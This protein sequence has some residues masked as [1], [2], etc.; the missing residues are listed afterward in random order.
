MDRGIRGF[1][2]TVADAEPDTIAVAGRAPVLRLEGVSKRFG[3]RAVLREVDLALAPGEVVAICGRNGAG[4]TTLLRIAAGL[5]IADAGSVRI[6]GLDPERD[7]RDYQRRVGLLAAG[8]SG[9]Y[10]RLPVERHLDFCAGI[11]LIP[12][13]VRRAA[14]ERAT[15]AFDL[16]A[17][18]GLR[19]DR[20]SMGQRQRLRLALA[21]LHDPELALLDEP[22]TSLDEEGGELL[23][24]R[25]DRLRASGGSALLCAPTGE[26]DGITVDRTLAID[27]GRLVTR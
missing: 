27:D 10:G 11:A 1:G 15:A 16:S 5:L 19:V 22:L 4:K 17:L 20:L 7:R 8:S 24:A 14:I 13:R 2:G 6:A 25:L 21:F 12:R 23:E 3:S 26:H 9:L 18:R